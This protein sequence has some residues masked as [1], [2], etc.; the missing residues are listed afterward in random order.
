MPVGR[1]EDPEQPRLAHSGQY[2]LHL[3]AAHD[4]AVHSQGGGIGHPPLVTASQL[5]VVR[6]P[7][8]APHPPLHV[9][10]Q[11]T[12]QTS[13]PPARGHH[14][15]Q[16]GQRSALL[17]DEPQVPAGLPPAH[18]A[19]LDDN[20]RQIATGQFISRRQPEHAAT[21]DHSVAAFRQA[22]GTSRQAGP[23]ASHVTAEKTAASPAATCSGT[24]PGH[25]R[26]APPTTP[27][28][29]SPVSVTG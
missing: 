19:A 5:R 23:N 1:G 26:P 20:D 4:P 8:V 10:P 29:M 24:P 2:R 28:V 22:D 16:L 6:K 21:D 12:A 25:K 7:Q 17:A 9:R 13:P 3:G 18:P 15:R 14:H 27:T 11:L